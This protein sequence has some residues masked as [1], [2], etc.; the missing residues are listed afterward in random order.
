[1]SSVIDSS[2]GPGTIRLLVL[3]K[4]KCGLTWDDMAMAG[5]IRPGPW[6]DMVLREINGDPAWAY[7]GNRLLLLSERSVRESI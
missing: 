5:A 2:F 6:G 3:M 7:F 4:C 1:M